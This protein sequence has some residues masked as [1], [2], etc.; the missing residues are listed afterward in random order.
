MAIIT[1]KLP[2]IQQIGIGIHITNKKLRWVEISR[3]GDRV[4]IVNY[5]SETVY[6]DVET[7]LTSLAERQKPLLPYVIVNIDPEVV[8]WNLVSA[9]VIEDSDILKRWIEK[10]YSLIMEGREDRDS[11]LIRHTFIGDESEEET[12][13]FFIAAVKNQEVK[14][15]ELL[16]RNLDLEPV[17]I[18]TGITEAA[19]GL[20]MT[21]EF[22]EG[23]SHLL[24]LFE[25]ES[26]LAE[27][28]HGMLQSITPIDSEKMS[29]DDIVDEVSLIINPERN[30]ERF[31]KT[32][33]VYIAGSSDQPGYM[34]LTNS[35][36]G[37]N[38][39]IDFLTTE[40][41]WKINGQQ[42][43]GEFSIAVGKA[44]K[45]LYRGLDSF[46][47]LDKKIED[48]V[49]METDKRDAFHL[50]RVT[51]A[52]ILSLF[53]ILK[54]IEFY[55][56]YQLDRAEQSAG[57]MQDRILTIENAM[58]KLT[59]ERHHI[60]QV[61]GLIQDRS[62]LAP[63]MHK[64]GNLTPVSVWFSEMNIKAFPKG[65][66][67]NLRGFSLSDTGVS[68]LME[69]LEEDPGV[70]NLV[71]R[72]AERIESDRFYPAEIYRV[73]P[74]IRFEIQLEYQTQ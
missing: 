26:Y 3:I 19:Y 73:K 39:D 16:I 27:Y 31:A 11:Y 56:G 9:P 25:D 22:I 44:M 64:I 53:L 34:D 51:G 37:K 74:L 55:S 61:Q 1:F 33:P 54:T 69:N 52:L 63:G 24:R 57:L 65:N 29:V 60:Q 13:K 23:H 30:S 72:S 59:T 4:R 67:T 42:L 46:N 71:L 47:F 28:S 70:R 32:K 15:I 49:L 10:Q 50:G 43:E 62:L 38:T 41:Y 17:L 35:R 5:D 45:Q 21:S 12:R 48:S 7:A 40:N 18:T 66:S 20:I 14:K 68:Q 58:E 6:T 2:F 8:I 36:G